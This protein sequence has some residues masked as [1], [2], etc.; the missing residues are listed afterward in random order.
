MT[1]I[2]FGRTRTPDYIDEPLISLEEIEKDIKQMK[3][4]KAWY[5]DK[6]ETRWQGNG[7]FFGKVIA[8]YL[9]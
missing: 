3:N 7:V 5:Y 6:C 9:E 4:R 2:Y 1:C 8:K